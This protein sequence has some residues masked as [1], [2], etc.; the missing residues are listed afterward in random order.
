MGLASHEGP[1]EEQAEKT[2]FSYIIAAEGW[3]EKL[4]EP[5]DVHVE[6]PNKKLMGRVWGKNPGYGATCIF[7]IVS[8][9]VILEEID[10]IPNK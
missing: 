6:A 9:L 2:E 4:T 5:T 3:K 10:N 7:L 1:T 8:A